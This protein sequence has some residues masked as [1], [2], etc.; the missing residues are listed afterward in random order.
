[1]ATR[2]TVIE[3]EIVIEGIAQSKVYKGKVIEQA[4]VK[5]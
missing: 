3:I 5:L 2:S 1:M 4:N